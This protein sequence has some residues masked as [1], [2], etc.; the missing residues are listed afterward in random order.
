M[1]LCVICVMEMWDTNLR[2]SSGKLDNRVF[3]ETGLACFFFFFTEAI[4][5]QM[6]KTMKGQFRLGYFMKCLKPQIFKGKV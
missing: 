1:C 2:L 4:N 3:G 6:S 5:F